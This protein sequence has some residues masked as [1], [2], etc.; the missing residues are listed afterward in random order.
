MCLGTII[1][2][3][4]SIFFLSSMWVFKQ[5]SSSPSC[6]LAANQNLLKFKNLLLLSMVWVLSKNSYRTEK[7]N[8]KY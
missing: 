8:W 2:L 1:V 5:N 3:I 6:V 7:K 4:F